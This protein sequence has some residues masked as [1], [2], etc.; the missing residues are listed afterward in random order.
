MIVLRETFLPTLT[1]HL[2]YY[3]NTKQELGMC[4]EILGDVI[5]ALQ[6]SE[7]VRMH[8]GIASIR[9]GCIVH[10][11]DVFPKPVVAII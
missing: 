11:L 2:Q 3:M 9:E 5:T 10:S 7:K 4:L 1:D 8:S 6:K